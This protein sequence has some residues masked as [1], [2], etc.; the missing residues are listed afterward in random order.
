[1]LRINRT[2]IREWAHEYDRHARPG[3]RSEE[4]PQACQGEPLAIQ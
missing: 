4:R 3:D 2:F 1:M